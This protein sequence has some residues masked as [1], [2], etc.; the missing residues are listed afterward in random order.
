[1]I[2][3]KGIL[4]TVLTASAAAVIVGS[5]FT[6]ESGQSIKRFI[7]KIRNLSGAKTP[8][9]DAIQSDDLASAGHA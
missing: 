1:M 9:S 2:S 3:G 7:D 5:M 4:I 6:K 8:E